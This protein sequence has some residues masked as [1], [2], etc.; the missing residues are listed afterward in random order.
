MKAVII[1]K[2]TEE[3]IE[4]TDYVVDVLG[5]K[6]T[7]ANVGEADQI[8]GEYAVENFAAGTFYWGIEE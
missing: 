8:T 3:V 6:I 1:I 2:A 5:A 7:D 4:I